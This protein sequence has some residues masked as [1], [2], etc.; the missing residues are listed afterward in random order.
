M[1]VNEA[2]GEEVQVGSSC[3]VRFF[4]FT[5]SGLDFLGLE[6]KVAGF[7]EEA[8]GLRMERRFAS[9]DQVL[10]ITLAVVEDSGWVSRATVE[11][12]GVGVSTASLVGTVITSCGAWAWNKD[13]VAKAATKTAEV[14][15]VK[16]VVAALAPDSEYVRNLQAVAAV[17]T[18][19][20]RN[21]NLLV[22]AY[23]AYQRAGEAAPKV[24][25]KHFAKV[26][27]KVFVNA[28]VTGTRFLPGQYGVTT[29]VKLVTA[30]GNVM[31]WF[32][33][34]AKDFEEGQKV[35]IAGSVKAND[36]YNGI[37][38]TVLTRCKIA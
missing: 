27:E 20:F 31:T 12:N 32:A 17:E 6:E 33:S 15:K 5:P 29:L 23:A 14:A 38:Q 2:T 19:S 11:K 7:A 8:K 9:V 16:A 10:A 18:V 22:S 25:S 36:F 1:V 30:E 34:G 4:G 21:L 13:I 28:T 35:N 3:L 26:G 37:A 24:E